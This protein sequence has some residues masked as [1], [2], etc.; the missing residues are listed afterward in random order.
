MALFNKNVEKIGNNVQV[1]AIL[2]KYCIR[3]TCFHR[4]GENLLLKKE[5]ICFFLKHF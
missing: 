1:E 3:R 2:V 5:K 4:T